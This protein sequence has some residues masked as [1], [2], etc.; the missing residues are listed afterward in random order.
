MYCVTLIKLRSWAASR[1]PTRPSSN[2]SEIPWTTEPCTGPCTA[3]RASRPSRRPSQTPR[4]K[5]AR[6]NSVEKSLRTE[7]ATLLN[8]QLWLDSTTTLQLCTE[9]RLL[10]SF[11]WWSLRTW[12]RPSSGTTRSTKVSPL[13]SS[14]GMWAIFSRSDFNYDIL[15]LFFKYIATLNVFSLLYYFLDYIY[16]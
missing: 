12:T 15:L 16:Y 7:R 5:A 8:Q 6:W 10:P 4:R 1:R 14:P 11:I 9:K 13:L 3:N 2:A